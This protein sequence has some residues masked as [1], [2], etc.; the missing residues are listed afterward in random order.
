MSR[1]RDVGAPPVSQGRRSK[2]PGLLLAVLA[3]LATAACAS[4]QQAREVQRLQA[5]AAYERGLA[6]VREREPALALSALQEAVSLDDS[7][8]AYWNALGWLYLQLGRLEEARLRF[9]KAVEL[10][11][12]FAEAHMNLGVAL[13]EAGRWEEAV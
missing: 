3:A 6:H 4:A 13:A 8:A 2:T 10:D 11:P 9:E 7:V 1:Q 12:N 5:Q